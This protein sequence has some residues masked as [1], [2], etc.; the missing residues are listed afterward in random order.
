MYIYVLYVYICLYIGPSL[1]SLTVQLLE[2]ELCNRFEE[3][4]RLW[5][6]MR[7]SWAAALDFW[8]IAWDAKKRSTVEEKRFLVLSHT[9]THTLSTSSKR[10][11]Y[12]VVGTQLHSIF[13]I[14]IDFALGQN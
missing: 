1:G 14:S 12:T 6:S 10:V 13:E 8:M 11:R 7:A 5:V 4:W 2:P 3:V 9:H